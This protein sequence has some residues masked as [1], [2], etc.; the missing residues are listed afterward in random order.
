M[1]GWV[2]SW[3]AR[4]SFA[5]RFLPAATLAGGL[6]LLLLSGCTTGVGLGAGASPTARAV[7]PVTA[8]DETEVRRRA[9]IRTQLAGSYFEQGQTTIAL[10]EIKQALAVDPGFSDAYNLR[11]LIYMRMNDAALAEES[12]RRAIALN[13]RDAGVLHNNG[14]LLCQQKRYDEADKFFLQALAIPTYAE[15][16]KTLMAQGICQSSAGQPELAERTLLRAY[17]LDPAN[18]V[19][20]YNL[21]QLLHKRAD[22]AKAQFYIRRLNNSEFANAESLWLGIKVERQLKDTVAMSQLA[23]Q[24]RRRYPESKELAAFDRGAFNE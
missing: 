22:Y 12:F 16:A 19:V 1:A 3:V 13:P 10:D 9:R 8:F 4:Q 11:G 2:T 24:L 6:G 7:E 21:A 18:P 14:W 17:E 20:G 5:V 23:S 15:K